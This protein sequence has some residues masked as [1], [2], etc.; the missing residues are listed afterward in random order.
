[1]KLTTEIVKIPEGWRASAFFNGQEVAVVI[2]E[3]EEEA[4]RWCK[5]TLEHS[6]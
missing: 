1:M 4:Q 5:E 3:T 2:E 6:E